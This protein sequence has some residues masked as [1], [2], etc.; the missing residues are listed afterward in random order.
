MTPDYDAEKT[1]VR[2][3][4]IDKLFE[5]HNIPNDVETAIAM[6]VSLVHRLV[7]TCGPLHLAGCVAMFVDLWRHAEAKVVTDALRSM[8]TEEMLKSMNTDD[9]KH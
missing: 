1:R 8:I 3:K 6:L 5:A 2:L 9:I 7:T 4:Q